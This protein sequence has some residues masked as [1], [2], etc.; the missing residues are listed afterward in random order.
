MTRRVMLQ[1]AA[2]PSPILQDA[3]LPS[4]KTWLDMTSRL[5]NK[6]GRSRKK[7]DTEKPLFQKDKDKASSSKQG[8]KKKTYQS[9]LRGMTLKPRRGKKTT[10][11]DM[12]LLDVMQA[13]PGANKP[14]KVYPNQS[15]L[16]SLVSRAGGAKK[17]CPPFCKRNV[18]YYN[19]YCIHDFLKDV[20]KRL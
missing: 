10:S 16:N 7:E 6:Y 12:S 19:H 3:P 8:G 13:F 14:L 1:P 5:E 15:T 9:M 20:I 2:G 4:Q 17:N 11:I 18:H